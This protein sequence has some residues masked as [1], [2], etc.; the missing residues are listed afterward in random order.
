MIV[1][2]DGDGGTSTLAPVAGVVGDL[3]DDFAGCVAT[4]DEVEDAD[5][6]RGGP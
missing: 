2:D 3:E 4:E 6:S 5:I 1:I